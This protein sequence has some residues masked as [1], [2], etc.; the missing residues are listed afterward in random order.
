MPPNMR[1]YIRTTEDD[2]VLISAARVY[3]NHFV[4]ES[5]VVD[6]QTARMIA[7]RINQCLDET[8]IR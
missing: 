2:G 7:R 3:D 4:W 6:R 1:A 8:A 5:L